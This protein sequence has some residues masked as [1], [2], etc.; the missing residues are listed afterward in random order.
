MQI[1]TDYSG[2]H[3]IL[4]PHRVKKLIFRAIDDL[5]LNLN[6]LNIFTEAASGNYVV[7]PLIAALAGAERVYAIATDSD[8]GKAD[9][10]REQ[11]LSLAEFFNSKGK[12]EVITEK[13]PDIINEVDIVTNLGFVRPIDEKFISSMNS[14]AVISLMCETWEV[15]K[16]DVDIEACKK[17]GILVLG[18]NEDAT[19]LKVFDFVGPLCLRMLFDTGIEVYNSNLL[20][21]SDDKF[22]GRIGSVLDKNG[23]NVQ[24]ATVKTCS[25]DR[26]KFDRLDAII[27]AD[28]THSDTI[29]GG[30]GVL[31]AEIIKDKYPETT[32]IQ[33]AGK[34]NLDELKSHNIEYYP[35]YYVGSYKMARTFGY[36]G[37]R[38]VIDLHAAG[39]RVGEIM[40]RNTRKY[41][42]LEDARKASMKDPLCQRLTQGAE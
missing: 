10:I 5:T 25:M 9:E 38:P 35:S 2:G 3:S 11:T 18:T 36:L 39:L 31:S 41:M 33:F 4:N 22:G 17:K 15:R 14:R 12:I 29:I 16:E 32:V 8:Y 7:T 40:A 30:D 27:V 23:A 28:Y 19:N 42:H 20:V 37:V 26:V 24:M 1:W 6:G 13:N 21:I 34:V